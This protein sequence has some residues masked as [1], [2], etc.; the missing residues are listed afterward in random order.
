MSSHPL[1]SVIEAADRA[2]A[3]EDF[4]AVMEFYAEDAVLV[5]R[6]G[7]DVRGKPAIRKAFTMI[8]D[9]FG[10]SLSIGQGKMTVLEGGGDTAL[11]LMETLLAF[12]GEGGRR[13]SLSRRATYV[14]RKD[15]KGRWLC[16]ID[17]SYGTDV[18]AD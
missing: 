9:Y 14:F 15:G 6:P 11:V 8:A 5:L 7:Q 3:D 17:N 16:L 1:R 4:D 13:Q 18:L 10:H 2:I 12:D